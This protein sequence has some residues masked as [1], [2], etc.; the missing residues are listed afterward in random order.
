MGKKLNM[1]FV[2]I[3]SIGLVGFLSGCTYGS[4]ITLYSNENNSN[5]K[6]S[7][8]YKKFSGYKATDITVAEGEKVE[9]NVSIESKEGKLG[10]TI[11]KKK[12]SKG[13]KEE[14]VYEGKELPTSNFKV[15]LDKTGDY[16]IK[17]T[18][19]KSNGSYKITWDKVDDK[20]DDK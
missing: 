13:G 18:G 7:M 8:T 15:I 1:L 5:S 17:V 16:N 9:V 20:M 19:E 14:T 2:L 10:L 3:L 12:D 11:L 6:M 4:S